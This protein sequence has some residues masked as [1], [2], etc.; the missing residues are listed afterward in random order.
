MGRATITA[1]ALSKGDGGRVAVWSKG[2]TEFRGNVS[3]QGGK[4]GGSGGYV[5]TSGAGNLR[6]GLRAHV[7]TF[8]R[9]GITGTWLLDP[10]SVIIESCLPGNCASDSGQQTI[11]PT[12]IVTS[13]ASSNV[14]IVATDDISVWDSLIYNSAHDLSLLSAGTIHID[15][16]IQNAAASNGGNINLISGWTG[17]TGSINHVDHTHQFGSG[18]NDVFIGGPGASA[19]GQD[20]NI[21]VG[22][23]S[24][25]TTVS[26]ASV[27]IESTSGYS[28]QLGYDGN[29]GGDIVVNATKD[30]IVQAGGSGSGYAQI[31]NGDPATGI[32]SA[33][34]NITLDVSGSTQL[35]T[36]GSGNSA[37]IGNLT[38][39]DSGAAETGNVTIVTGSLAV[40]AP[41]LLGEI[42]RDDMQGSSNPVSGAGG[43]FT[44]ALT[45]ATGQPPIGSYFANG[46]FYSSS[47]T[48]SLVS[49]SGLDFTSS[50]Q[51]S[52]AGALNIVGGWDVAAVSARKLIAKGVSYLIGNAAYGASGGGVTIGGDATGAVAVGSRHGATTV[53]GADIDVD[54]ENG[55]SQIGF[56]GAGNGAI[57]V[58]A[59]GDINLDAAGANVAGIGNGGTSVAGNTSGAIAL[60]TTGGSVN[61][62]AQDSSIATVGNLGTGNASESSSIAIDTQGGALTIT[63]GGSNSLAQIG[64]S[65][66]NGT[67]GK[68]TGDITIA[69]ADVAMLSDGSASSAQIGNGNDLGAQDTGLVQ[70]NITIDAASLTMTGSAAAPREAAP[71][72]FAAV[73]IGN[74]GAG[75]TGGD[76]EVTTSGDI[77]L[78]QTGTGTTFIGNTSSAGEGSGATTVNAGGDLA[79]SSD[80][81]NAFAGIAATGASTGSVDV[82]AHGNVVMTALDGARTLV[83]ALV[84]GSG[85]VDVSVT[86]QTGKVAIQSIGNGSAVQI[87][88][89]EA[90]GD[91]GAVTGNVAVTAAKNIAIASSTGSSA[92]IGNLGDAGGSA[93]GDIVL[94]VGNSL[95]IA[96]ADSSLIGDSAASASGDVNIKANSLNGD[97]DPSLT[98]DLPN[99]DFTLAL[100]GNKT[101]TLGALNYSGDHTLSISNGGDLILTGA[102]HDSGSGDISLKSGGMLTTGIIKTGSAVT[103]ASAGDTVIG[104]VQAAFLKMN[105]GGAIDATGA[106]KTSGAARLVAAGDASLGA[107]QAASLSVKS[108]GVLDVTGTIKTTGAASLT[109]AD[110]TSIGA[111]KAASL[112]VKSGGALTAGA[113]GTTG[114]VTLRSA[115]D[116]SIG[117]VRAASLAVKTGGA[118]TTGAIKTTGVTNLTAAGNASIGAVRAASLNVKSGGALDVTGA[119]KT[120]GATS[121]TSTDDTSIGAVQAA[122]LSVK[123]GGAIDVGGAIKTAD[124]TYL[125][126]A[127][128]THIGAV[129]AASLMVKSGGAIGASGNIAT[130]G[131]TSLASADATSVS[132]VNAGSLNVKSGGA[133]NANG[134][135]K[136]AGATSLMSADDTSIGAVQAASL[137]VKSGG[138]IDTT[139][140][141]KTSGAVTLVSANGTAVNATLDAASLA[142]TTGGGVAVNGAVTTNGADGIAIDA[143][144]DI[145]F[146]AT[147]QN[148]GSGDIAVTSKGDV[149][150][151]GAS[152]I[153][154]VFI[155]SRHGDLTLV[156]DNVTL[157]A[158]NGYAQLGYRGAGS[159]GID[160]TSK[161]NVALDGGAHTGDYAQIGNGGYQTNGDESGDITLAVQGDVA[162]NGGS[163]N[164]AYAQIGH[165]GA[166]ADANSTGYTNAGAIAV[167]ADNV[168]LAAGSGDAAY[169]QIG[170]GGYLLG[171][172]LTGQGDNSGDITIAAANS[173][174][175][176]GG[177]GDA[178]AQ[179]GNGGG[180]VNANAGASASGS[181]DGEIS[182]TAGATG[183]VTLQAGTGENAYVQVGNGG[184]ASDAPTPAVAGN[185]ADSGDVS[186]SDLVLTGSDTGDNGYAQIGNGDASKNN[187]GNV[188]GNTTIAAGTVTVTNGTAAN[189]S[190]FIG[191]ATA[192][193]KVTGAVSGYAP[194]N[195][196]GGGTLVSLIEDST[197]PPAAIDFLP[198]AAFELLHQDDQLADRLGVEDGADP[199]AKLA[200]DDSYEGSRDA[201][202]AT[203]LLGDSLNGEHGHNKAAT[204]LSRVI[205]PGVLREFAVYNSRQT[206]GAPGTEDYSSW[207]NQALWQW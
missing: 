149:T 146:A 56:H 49:T 48:L 159:G 187:V 33:T 176:N 194:A 203:E 115:D 192:R 191:G 174:T 7:S 103:L 55:A 66:P 114:A 207:G 98:S 20:Q 14:Q 18:G 87:G 3:A 17:D 62:D 181:N 166:Q 144:G 29:G 117:A 100:G 134:T 78:S 158:K 61:I 140:A 39:G 28:S 155:G 128:G 206:G 156:A 53:A 57:A 84:Y 178:Y 109:S 93:S 74:A 16:S 119:I 170:H 99:G 91:S 127:D 63:S 11:D 22:S 190:A 32:T 205:I 88:N 13:L 102:L 70:G 104:A 162:L 80:G 25:T 120:A 68:L 85:G 198:F 133:L 30:V 160:V 167:S 196:V 40:D 77:A 200:D 92:R 157:D 97:I 197:P 36:G 138:A 135:I 177:G 5:E 69:A 31:G 82:T 19:D 95:K 94:S 26:G 86:A 185:F 145:V 193:G 101:L 154:D 75:T 41:D 38:D 79:L 204:G 113:V 46:L 139:G 8:A 195:D 130:S 71:N 4:H 59:N 136:T 175:L 23:A 199:L 106:I 165:G 168:T 173:V 147:V 108:G 34:G 122:S 6:I 148:T 124:A 76:L 73:R 182:V 83:G 10:D 65:A 126:S 47:H 54:A 15:A 27:R 37:W 180:Q 153:G 2:Q 179:I 184:Y 123:S 172:G 43:D 118:L 111:V 52:G 164:Q 90:G 12:T 44:L 81:A 110:D 163:G 105:S 64:N 21:S 50:V 58:R 201:D 89:A 112:S 132:A 202:K 1:D 72:P 161:G 143:K 169:A 141:I 183:D 142:V 60:A 116:T 125:T 151:G 96:G 131:A 129:Q 188:S 150:V 45:S 9:K 171:S 42:I 152:A 137:T 107:V 35:I 51:N 67:S 186:V 189:A 121:L 24:G